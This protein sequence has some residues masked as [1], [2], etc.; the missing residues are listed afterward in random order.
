MSRLSKVGRKCLDLFW[1]YSERKISRE[2]MNKQL[3]RLKGKQV[4]LPLEVK[5]CLSKNT[6]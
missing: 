2:Y 3:D 4:E 1:L 5:L 6:L